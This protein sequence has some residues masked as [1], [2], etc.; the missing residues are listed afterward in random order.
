VP[1]AS[2]HGIHHYS[3]ILVVDDSGA[4]R[5]VVRK[6]LTQLGYKRID[7]ASDGGSALTKI[8]EK[9]FDLVI[10]DWN[11]VPMGGDVLLD[12]V[13]GDKRFTNLPF[14]MMTGD[15]TIDKIIQAKRAGVSCFINKPFGA[16]GLQAKIVELNMECRSAVTA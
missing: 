1:R 12:R 7:E 10:S 3:E 6:L 9:H 8:S 5:S 14:I 13:R 2:L 15:R 16:D 11:M 4:V